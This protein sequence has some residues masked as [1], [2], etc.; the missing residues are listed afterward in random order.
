MNDAYQWNNFQF[1]S[2]KKPPKVAKPKT[3]SDV[4]DNILELLDFI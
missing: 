3:Q 1:S 2:E 4:K